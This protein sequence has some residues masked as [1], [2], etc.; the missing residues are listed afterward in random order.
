MQGFLGLEM[1]KEALKL[2]RKFLEAPHLNAEQFRESLIVVENFVHKSKRW[3]TLLEK[4]YSRL[5]PRDQEK[6]R[7]KMLAFYSGRGNTD[8][9]L[10][11]LPKRLN[12]RGDLIELLITWESWLD[13]DRM[14]ELEKT[15]PIMSSAIRTA[16]AAEMS[17]W[18]FGLN[19]PNWSGMMNWII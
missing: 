16:K 17:A 3:Q 4:A 10:R 19:E 8:A 2:A 6:V 13:N 9:V 5:N 18:L 11:F 14:N 7:P 1:K 15:I 12:Y